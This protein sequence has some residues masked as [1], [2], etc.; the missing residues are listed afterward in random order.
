MV[1]RMHA[2]MTMMIM[3]MAI[4]EMRRAQAEELCSLFFLMI[5]MQMMVIGYES[6]SEDG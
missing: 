2:V 1:V 5:M 6:G 3:M 4:G